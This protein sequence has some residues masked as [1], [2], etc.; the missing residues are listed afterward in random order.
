MESCAVVK[1]NVNTWYF[2]CFHGNGR[3]KNGNN[4][5]V[6][7][8]LPS[9][10]IPM[11]HYASYKANQN[12]GGAT[13]AQVCHTN[14][15]CREL[16]SPTQ[17]Q[18]MLFPVP[19]RRGQMDG[20]MAES[21][22]SNHI[23]L[24]AANPERGEKHHIQVCTVESH[25]LRNKTQ[26]HTWKTGRKKTKILISR[27]QRWCFPGG[28]GGKEPACQRRRRG[29][30]SCVQKIPW[31]RKRQPT[32]VLLPGESRGQ[33]SLARLQSIGS[34]KSWTRLSTHFKF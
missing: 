15:A 16:I 25:F 34:Q 29:F 22:A 3:N 4:I 11:T 28:T 27:Y 30:D 1:H 6:S 32:P 14:S 24:D 7:N 31:S 2:S 33:R 8:G 21:T 19:Q 18:G 17:Q 23:T 12:V 9:A 5:P 13:G 20:L 26:P 10:G